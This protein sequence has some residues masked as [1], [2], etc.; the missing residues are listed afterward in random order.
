MHLQHT[1]ALRNLADFESLL[2]TAGPWL[3]AFDFPFGLPR[4]F[5]DQHDLGTN[6][7][8]VIAEVHRRCANRMAFR[9]MIDEWGNTRPAGHRLIHRATDLALLGKRSISPLQTRY[10]PVG[11]MYYEGLQRLVA[12]DVNIPQLRAG[13]VARTALEGYPALL[14]EELVGRRSYKNA[15]STERLQARKDIVAGLEQGATKLAQRLVLTKAQGDELVADA[16]GDRLDAVM[17]LMQASWAMGQLSYGLP[18][19]ID[20]VE[21]WIIS[22]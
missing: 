22:S 4:D 9:T 1:D 13:D 17:C 20:P 18:A 21:G 7:D 8:A 14:A 11:F 16:S 10:V 2:K 19:A 15:D 5:V 12:A 6:A 3:G